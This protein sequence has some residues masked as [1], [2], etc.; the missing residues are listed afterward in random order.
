L[1][2]THPFMDL[3][4][5]DNGKGFDLDGVPLEE[6]SKFGLSMMLERAEAIGASFHLHSKPN[7]G[8]Q[9]IIKMALDGE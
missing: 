3:V 4:I 8:T 2:V 7:L 1:N 9:V 6:F 5:E